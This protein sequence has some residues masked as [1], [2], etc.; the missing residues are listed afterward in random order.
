M[1]DRD[2]GYVAAD[3]EWSFL[4]MFETNQLRV[5]AR[6]VGVHSVHETTIERAVSSDEYVPKAWRFKV[7]DACTSS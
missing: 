2:G 4:G 7:E 3:D 6:E 1:C 5:I